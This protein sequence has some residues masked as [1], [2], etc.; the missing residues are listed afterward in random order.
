MNAGE[1]P[2]NDASA[3]VRDSAEPLRIPLLPAPV[4]EIEPELV[5]STLLRVSIPLRA[6][7]MVPLLAISTLLLLLAGPML[8]PRTPPEIEPAFDTLATST[9][10]TPL[11]PPVMVPVEVLVTSPF[12]SLT[13]CRTPEILPELVT[14]PVPLKLTP[15]LSAPVAETEPALFTAPPLKPKMPPPPNEPPAPAPVM[16]PKLLTVPRSNRSP[17]LVPV[18]EAPERML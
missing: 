5:K 7:V 3:C 14:D 2:Q 12:C 13:P 11:V 17:A 6:P 15:A 4:P 1:I 9:I 8:M 10:S 18:T 16:V